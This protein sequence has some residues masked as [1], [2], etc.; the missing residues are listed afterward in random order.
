MN[1]LWR[2]VAASW[3]VWKMLSDILRNLPH[4]DF[5][6]AKLKVERLMQNYATWE[7]RG[8]VSEWLLIAAWVDAVSDNGY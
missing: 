3:K 7:S 8:D 2:L 4:G 1:I 5:D 6:K